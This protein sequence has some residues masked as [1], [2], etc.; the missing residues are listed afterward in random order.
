MDWTGLESHTSISRLDST[1]LDSPPP[2]P[3][4]VFLLL[5]PYNASPRLDPLAFNFCSS[6]PSFFPK[7]LDL[8]GRRHTTL[9]TNFLHTLHSITRPF[10]V[11]RRF[12]IVHPQFWLS[13]RRS[14]QSSLS[15]ASSRLDRFSF[16]RAPRPNSVQRLGLEL[17]ASTL[18]FF[19]QLAA[20]TPLPAALVGRAAIADQLTFSRSSIGK[21]SCTSIVPKARFV[22]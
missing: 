11:A 10:P 6:A 18:P 8:S 17:G 20:L 7:D 9:T 4:Y 13:Q 19:P 3:R 22:A 14:Y 1:R 16:H 15:V 21:P 12:A 5:P 2:P